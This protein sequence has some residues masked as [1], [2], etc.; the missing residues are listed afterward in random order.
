MRGESGLRLKPHG[1]DRAMNGLPA[2]FRAM[3]LPRSLQGQ[4]SAPRESIA[5]GRELWNGLG[6]PASLPPPRCRQGCRRSQ[7]AVE[8]GVL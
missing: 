2:P 6:P 1:R 7:D 8:A 5:E 3:S 4:A